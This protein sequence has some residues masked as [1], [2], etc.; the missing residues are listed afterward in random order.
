M[1]G[2]EFGIDLPRHRDGEVGRGKRYI[3]GRVRL[4]SLEGFSRDLVLIQDD[5][6]IISNRRREPAPT[7][8]RQKRRMPGVVMGVYIA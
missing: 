6:G 3:W 2:R 7:R 8:I 5:E 4:T 1:V